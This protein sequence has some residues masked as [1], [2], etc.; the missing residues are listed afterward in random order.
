MWSQRPIAAPILRRT[1]Q[2]GAGIDD[3]LRHLVEIQAGRRPARAER[4]PGLRLAV[5]ELA[6][7]LQRDV[8]RLLGTRR[9]PDV[10]AEHARE[11]VRPVALDVHLVEVHARARGTVRV[12][13]G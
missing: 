11:D 7:P 3:D 5:A 12:Q 8:V 9:V 13:P 1:G 6:V 2:A 4:G 10:A